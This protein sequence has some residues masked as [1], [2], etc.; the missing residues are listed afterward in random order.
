MATPITKKTISDL[1]KRIGKEISRR[2]SFGSIATEKNKNQN[3]N[4]KNPN[5]TTAEDI[6]S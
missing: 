3:L 1:K 6:N 4:L 5:V 2:S